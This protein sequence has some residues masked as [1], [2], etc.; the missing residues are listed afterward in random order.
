MI[1]LVVAFASAV[2]PE[3]CEA[4]EYAYTAKHTGTNGGTHFTV[5][6]LGLTGVCNQFGVKL[7]NGNAELTRI[8]NG[9][10]YAKIGYY[11]GVVRG[12]DKKALGTSERKHLTMMMQYVN[13]PK[14]IKDFAYVKAGTCK[15][16]VDKARQVNVPETFEI[17]QGIPRNK[18]QSFLVWKNTDPITLTLRKT[19]T[20]AAFSQAAGYNFTGISYQVYRSDRVTPVG[21]LTCG[22]DGTT[23]TL[24]GLA[25]GTYYA[26]EVRTNGFYAMNDAWLGVTVSAGGAGIFQAADTP[27]KGKLR[28]VKGSTDSNS[29]KAGYGFQGIIYGLYASQSESSRLLAELPLDA[30]GSSPV[31]ADIPVGTRY[32]K[33]IKT[34]DFYQLSDKW[35]PVNISAGATAVL[36]SETVQDE[37]V[38]GTLEIVK[39]ITNGEKSEDTFLF[40]LISTENS[41]IAYRDIKVKGDG[42]PVTVKALAGTYIL[43]ETDSGDYADETGEQ[44]VTVKEGETIRVERVNRMAK[45]GTL[46]VNKYIDDGGT[47]AGFRFRVTGQLYNQG[48]LTAAQ[49]LEAADPRVSCGEE[50]KYTFGEWSVNEEELAALNQAAK[51]RKTGDYLVTLTCQASPAEPGDEGGDDP[52][53]GDGSGGQETGNG[54]EKEAEGDDGQADGSGTGE[55]VSADGQPEGSGAGDGQ[56]GDPEGASDS[57]ADSG[58]EEPDVQPR[59]VRVQP[60][61]HLSDA[62]YDEEN[63]CYTARVTDRKEASGKENDL[64]I[65]VRDFTWT[66]AATMYRDLKTGKDYTML[67]TDQRGRGMHEE[68][69]TEGIDPITPGEYTV[70][71][72]P[73]DEQSERYHTPQAQKVEYT[74]GKTAA[75]VFRFDN[76]AKRT[77]VRLKKT[78]M[79]GK[80]AGINFLLS[81][82]TAYGD[83]VRR[84]GTTDEEGSI[85]FGELQKG[86]YVI[87]EIGWDPQKYANPYPME[88][89]TRPAKEVKVTGEEEETITV[90][91]EN[92]PYAQI[93][94]TKKDSESGRFLPGA[95]FS[96]INRTKD[97]VEASFQIVEE[98]GCPAVKMISAEESIREVSGQQID[99]K[100]EGVFVMLTGLSSGDSY[101]VVETNS[102]LGYGVD[103]RRAVIDADHRQVHEIVVEDSPSKIRTTATDSHSGEHVALAGT[104]VRI[105]DTIRYE[106]LVPGKEY[107]AEGRLMDR[108]DYLVSRDPKDIKPARDARGREITAK[109]TF[110]PETANGEVK[111]EFVFDGSNLSGASLVAYE[112]LYS[113]EGLVTD[114][115]DPEDQEQT[116]DFPGIETTALAEDTH[117][118][119][120]NADG[121][122]R[123]T[124]TVSYR[125]LVPGKTYHLSGVLM[126]KQ[127]GEP[128]RSGG[129]EVRAETE[130]T[131]EHASGSV[132]LEFVFDGGAL[133]G[134]TAVAF[135]ELE[136]NSRIVAEHKDLEDQAQTVEIPKIG[137]V[138]D[139]PAKDRI[140]DTVDYQ[141][142]IPGEKYIMS[143]VLVDRK[144]GAEIEGTRSE[145]EFIPPKSSGRV[146]I[147]FQISADS[148]LAEGIER[149]VVFETCS[150]MTDVSGEENLSPVEIASHRDLGDKDQTVYLPEPRGSAAT[151][152]GSGPGMLA[153]LSGLLAA[154]AGLAT[155]AL[156]RILRWRLRKG[157]E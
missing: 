114:H 106:N 83:A 20:N 52:A 73:T 41:E 86:T 50:G 128:I 4:A 2:A 103:D 109:A 57:G 108:T 96:L 75:L 61:I 79:D 97:K 71:E 148:L 42:T 11:W 80:I 67:V 136:I 29:I 46:Q 157:A 58:T 120:T 33:E 63:K 64:E 142:L 35:Y 145:I 69:G 113:A 68:T 119:I 156:R 102:P 135:E 99:A 115:E 19:S 18:S 140:E 40:D 9:T 72:V 123:I 3:I 137:T 23:N 87:E 30:E 88:G 126:D 13:N 81:G 127:T 38:D 36:G 91:F 134:T 26:R 74:G 66:G 22:A 112:K 24:S 31:V 124:D 151:G 28:L 154:I 147:M 118:H 44:K 130:F 133:A 6:A 111:V 60:V 139:R 125:N 95:T 27:L 25:Q 49:L 53:G 47:R 16:D 14:A 77:P 43:R 54:E 105:I 70:T 92:V 37:P 149:V 144:T 56:P 62:V 8:S 85:D 12:F 100:Q 1:T 65:S 121:E 110:T 141:G 17:Y 150:I 132:T 131:A 101:E 155:L 146:K 55:G 143:G 15:K 76:K 90:A 138:A 89:R 104:Q 32:L 117:M 107:R 93:L 10:D 152:D 39:K 129:K 34:N 98:D 122:V 5:P 59:T 7:K 48:I 45:P 51:E 94:L 84:T 153:A 21:V 78:S 116:V 82:E